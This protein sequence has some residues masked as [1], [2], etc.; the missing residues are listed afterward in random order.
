MTRYGDVTTSQAPRVHPGTG[1][2]KV[3]LHIS[4]LG[5]AD[6]IKEKIESFAHTEYD[7]PEFKDKAH[8]EHCLRNAGTSSDE[9]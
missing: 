7:R 9:T 6:R 1:V 5:G 2:R 4:Y 3:G 8:V